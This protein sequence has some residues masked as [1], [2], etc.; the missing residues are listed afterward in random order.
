MFAAAAIV[1]G[2]DWYKG[3]IG[4]FTRNVNERNS[5]HPLKK[6]IHSASHHTGP[7]SIRS[8]FLCIE[9]SQLRLAQTSEFLAIIPTGAI[10]ETS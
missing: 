7:P 4:T 10:S 5:G 2:I 6:V 8:V 9:A 1:L 3:L